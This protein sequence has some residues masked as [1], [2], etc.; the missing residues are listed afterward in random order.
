MARQSRRRKPPITERQRRARRR[1]WLIIIGV[2]SVVIVLSGLLVAYALRDQPGEKFPDEGYR[3]LAA[4][5]TSYIWGTT[6]PTS[7]PHSAQHTAWGEHPETVA[8]WLQVHNLAEGGVIM[9]YNCP[10]GCDDVVAELRD[11][12]R[13]KGTD[14]LI[15]HPYTTMDSTIALTAWTRM[16]TLDEVDRDQ[17]EDFIDAYRGIDHRR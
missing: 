1:K 8:E 9:H 13:D 16:L 4:E 5:P 17:I 6:P 7:G 2:V 10:E 14:Q 3:E 15:L 11:I 12:L